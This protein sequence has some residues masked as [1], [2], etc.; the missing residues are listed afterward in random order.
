MGEVNKDILMKSIFFKVLEEG[1]YYKLKHTG[2]IYYIAPNTFK[3]RYFLDGK[4][5]L[6]YGFSF[7]VGS[8]L[9]FAYCNET[10]Y[11]KKWA[12][13]KEILE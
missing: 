2:E 8:V 11:N 12:L 9:A 10:Y 1:F 7:K 5:V 4:G 13:T 6:S 3:V